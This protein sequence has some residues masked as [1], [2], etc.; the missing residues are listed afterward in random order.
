MIFKS[1]DLKFSN[2]CLTKRGLDVLSDLENEKGNEYKL[3]TILKETLRFF[4]NDKNKY[5]YKALTEYVY[6]LAEEKE[7]FFPSEAAKKAYL[8]KFII[9]F[10][11]YYKAEL[12]RYFKN[13]YNFEAYPSER[14][15]NCFGLDVSITPDIIF[16]GNNE[17]E[18]VKYK[19]GKPNITEN[20]RV[21]DKS[22]QTSL[23]IYA[24]LKYGRQCAVEADLQGTVTI[25]AAYYYLQK[26]DDDFKNC[27]IAGEY[28]TKT[29]KSNIGIEE[30]IFEFNT[31]MMT[32]TPNLDGQF[33][34]QFEAFIK[35]SACKGSDVCESCSLKSVCSYRDLP[36]KVEFKD[37]SKKSI[38]DLS[39]NKVQT[40]A[41][42]F[43][44]GVARINAGAGSGKTLVTALRAVNLMSEGVNPKN[45]LLITFTDA[46]AK[47]M[48][49]RIE[50][51][52]TEYDVPFDVSELTV[53]T[54]NAFA[55]NIVKKEYARL[56]F[57]DV[58]TVIDDVEKSMI[59][60]SILNNTSQIEGLDYVNFDM[61]MYKAAGAVALVKHIFELIKINNFSNI[62]GDVSQIIEKSKYHVTEEII[63][64]IFPL[65]DDYERKLKMENLIDYSDQELLM[66]EL[67][68]IE[69]NYL[70]RFGIKHIFVDEFQD[71]SEE[72]MRFIKKLMT[73]KSFESL[74][75]VGDDSQAIY[76]FRNTS[77]KNIITFFDVINEPDPDFE[78]RHIDE[79]DM[80]DFFLLENYRSTPAIIQFANELNKINLNRID[81]NLIA[82]NKNNG[83]SP[84]AL[85]FNNK[86][87]EYA[88]IIKTIKMELANGRK[89][90]DICFIAAT[91][92]ELLE[93]QKR[94]DLEGVQSL[95]LNP[96]Y[97]LENPK[98]LAL[99]ALSHA[100]KNPECTEEIMIYL[101]AFY[102]GKI[103]EMDKTEILS[104]VNKIKNVM[105]A[106][107]EANDNDK[108][109][110]FKKYAE[111][112]ANDDELY[113][114]FFNKV[115]KRKD[116]DK[117]M[118]YL[119]GFERFGKSVT[120]KRI[121]NYTGAVILTT[122]HSSKGLEWPVV[123]N[124]ISKYHTGQFK[125]DEDEEEKRRLFFVSITR[126]KERLVVTGQIVAYRE[127]IK[128]K[129]ESYSIPVPNIFMDN[130]VNILT[131]QRL[132]G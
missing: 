80:F 62:P 36:E 50:A 59:V 121:E 123:I 106:L 34:P 12:L 11:R 95:L 23:E 49:E 55:Y 58:P 57:T 103:L 115:F 16:Y 63:D 13:S 117:L 100:I 126:A 32:S 129:S 17:I 86:E 19:C 69:S 91:R 105:I 89:S 47:E 85:A 28:F 94:L 21:Q 114:D 75:V 118:K 71:S 124:S 83:F 97:V 44:R 51:Y 88:H 130:A 110:V 39:L 54:F 43:K 41:I 101:N 79:E 131:G 37:V 61:D 35:G 33:A 132:I 87:E 99:L 72:Q 68:E 3:S 14:T 122:A 5:S 25:K 119:M 107:S 10:N 4:L 65:Y 46:G 48:K 24:M 73:T 38:K 84:E 66:F 112:I 90:N 27:K 76:S 29:K 116:F 93:V 42:S 78:V 92:S 45:I 113:I 8:E 18:I 7:L 22:V 127:T 102:E 53:T 96:E 60:E 128:E 6:I 109:K 67:F 82:K 104:A 26:P 125:N 98:V 15:I 120:Y 40:A 31:A 2:R 52:S 9:C 111:A 30:K 56:G 108:L 77:P 81:K 1:G 74:M 64:K 20:G 70:E